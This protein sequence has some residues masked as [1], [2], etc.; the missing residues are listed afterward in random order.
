MCQLKYGNITK[1]NVTGDIE[2]NA[3]AGFLGV[4]SCQG[5]T[6]MNELL[7]HMPVNC[8]KRMHFQP[9]RMYQFNPRIASVPAMLATLLERNSSIEELVLKIDVFG[10]DGDHMKMLTTMPQ[11]ALKKI[12]VITDTFQAWRCAQALVKSPWQPL[13]VHWSYEHEDDEASPEDIAGLVHAKHCIRELIIDG[14][15]CV[16]HW[17][18]ELFARSLL[19]IKISG[20]SRK[21]LFT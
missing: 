5:V 18:K 14:V 17:E 11:P 20:V 7:Q 3:E 8:M 19:N 16:K 13:T 10:C 15:A 12:R 2:Y 1:L 6:V 21:D 4:Y 9:E